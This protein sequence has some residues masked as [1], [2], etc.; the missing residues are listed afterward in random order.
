MT[1]FYSQ[2]VMRHKAFW[3]VWKICQG[4]ACLTVNDKNKELIA[5]RGGVDALAEVSMGPMCLHG[6]A[7]GSRQSPH[8]AMNRPSNSFCVRN[9]SITVKYTVRS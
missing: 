6:M 9:S 7:T 4:L 2:G 3:T 8:L 1:H 5:A